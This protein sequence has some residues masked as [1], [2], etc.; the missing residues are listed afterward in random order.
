MQDGIF[1][2]THG[3]AA[4]IEPVQPTCDMKMDGSTTVISISE[5]KITPP[6]INFERTAEFVRVR[7]L[8][9]CISLGH[10]DDIGMAIGIAAD[11]LPSPNL[12]CIYCHQKYPP[13]D[14]KF[15]IMAC[16]IH[17]E[18][19][20]DPK[21]V[22]SLIQ[23]IESLY[24]SVYKQFHLDALAFIRLSNPT[25]EI[26]IANYKKL[27]YLL[28]HYFKKSVITTEQQVITHQQ[29]LLL[30]SEL[31]QRFKHFSLSF[32]YMKQLLPKEAYCSQK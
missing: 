24:S 25:N 31:D 20:P 13:L 7:N 17:R 6:T 11:L 10:L 5:V 32:Q 2:M 16:G 28:L 29:V 3:Y 8:S 26:V 19:L 18:Y 27:Q 22:A 23:S 12:W 14:S 15:N 21:K 1:P 4:S 9:C 30:L